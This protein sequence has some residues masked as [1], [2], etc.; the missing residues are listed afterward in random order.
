MKRV[1]YFVKSRSVLFGA[2]IAATLLGGATTAVVMAAIPDSNGVI[3]ACQTNL[4]GAL[5]VIDSS[6]QSCTSSETALNWD[7]HAAQGTKYGDYISSAFSNTS[8]QSIDLSFRNMPNTDFTNSAFGSGAN[9]NYG[10][11]SNSNFTGAGLEMGSQNVNFTGST[12]SGADLSNSGL[13][14]SNFTGADLSN[15]TIGNSNFGG[16][17][18]SDANFTN[19]SLTNVGFA[20]ATGLDSANLS[21]VTWSGVNCPDQTNSDDNGNTCIG[22][23][24]P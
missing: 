6:N 13:N 2:V 9:F 1:I 7:Q 21:G 15:L 22:H 24:T 18:F 8:L 5:R 17:D 4:T 12:F 20:N 14:D 19:S 10:N 3:N 11:F 23:L 16:S